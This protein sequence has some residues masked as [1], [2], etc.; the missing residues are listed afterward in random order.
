MDN[1]KVAWVLL[2][3]AAGLL[4]A[5]C[6]KCPVGEAY[7]NVAWTTSPGTTGQ[8]SIDNSQWYC[9]TSVQNGT[10]GVAPCPVATN[11]E[12]FRCPGDPSGLQGIDFRNNKVRILRACPVSGPCSPVI[13]AWIDPYS[14]ARTDISQ[15]TIDTGVIDGQGVLCFTSTGPTTSV[16]VEWYFP[17]TECASSSPN[18]IP[19]V[20][21]R[22]QTCPAPGP[23][24][25]T[26]SCNETST[27]SCGVTGSPNGKACS[28]PAGTA[29][30]CPTNGPG[31]CASFSGC[32]CS[33][34]TKDA[35]GSIQSSCDCPGG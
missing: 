34:V 30:L 3:G 14:G 28:F 19:T 23:L 24:Q 15:T 8:A 17:D 7:Y 29:G 11:A 25:G 16:A 22:V 35:C 18:P 32:A 2:A 12:G 20:G 10:L 21:G 1:R 33:C 6:P 9:V 26:L 27:F 31:A 5:G 4:L 13:G